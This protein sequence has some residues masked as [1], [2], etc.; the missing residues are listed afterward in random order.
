LSSPRTTRTCTDQRSTRSWK[1]PWLPFSLE[2]PS[3]QSLAWQQPLA[4][5]LSLFLPSCCSSSGV[6]KDPGGT[7]GELQSNVTTINCDK[8]WLQLLSCML[9]CNHM[10]DVIDWCGQKP[11]LQTT[12][13]PKDEGPSID[14][15]FAILPLSAISASP[16][17]AGCFLLNYRLEI[18]RSRGICVTQFLLLISMTMFHF[19][20]ACKRAFTQIPTP[21]APKY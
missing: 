8:A 12:A 17:D 3:Q 7:A 10:V 20:T 9:A 1:L 14:A 11:G 19:N 21:R 5:L 6:E 16:P 15:H 2:W 4:S 18:Y 13:R